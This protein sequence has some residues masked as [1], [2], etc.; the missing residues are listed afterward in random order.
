MMGAKQSTISAK[1]RTHLIRLLRKCICLLFGTQAIGTLSAMSKEM[2]AR[3]VYTKVVCT[4][5]A[6][7]SF[8]VTKYMLQRVKKVFTRITYLTIKGNISKDLS[9]FTSPYSVLEEYRSTSIKT[10]IKNEVEILFHAHDYRSRV[11]AV[12]KV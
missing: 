11:N 8:V 1:T 12:P 9:A 3:K 10:L 4:Q 2:S 7:F 5:C 6:T